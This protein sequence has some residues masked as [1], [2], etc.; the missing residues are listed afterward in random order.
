MVNA[1]GAQSYTWQPQGSFD[2]VLTVKPTV[3]EIYTVSGKNSF[4]CV[5]T[6]TIVLNV[7][8]LPLV[9]FDSSSITVCRGASPV[10]EYTGAE[11]Y[12][13]TPEILI[14]DSSMSYFLF[15]ESNSCYGSDTI[16]V[17]VRE[18]NLPVTVDEDLFIP[19]GFS[20]NN[21]GINDYF[22][23]KGLLGKTVHL[24]IF[25]RW[26][27]EVYVKDNYDN[28]W[29]GK[30]NVKGVFIDDN[31]LSEGTYFYLLRFK[32]TTEKPIHGFLVLRY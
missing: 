8:N 27:N 5:S 28:S 32:D 15:G 6:S 13:I 17:L 20:P 3:S 11:N 22:V 26:G 19:Q 25:N 2:S 21:D 10:F 16:E 1:Q 9:R 12:T 7:R 4:N 14:P 24:T 29:S 31:K 30:A 23:I 18:C